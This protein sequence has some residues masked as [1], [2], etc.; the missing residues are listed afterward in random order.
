M[1]HQKLKEISQTAYKIL[2]FPES[3][4]VGPPGTHISYEKI[5]LIIV[6]KFFMLLNC[7]PVDGR[8]GRVP[9]SSAGLPSS[10]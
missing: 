10:T 5:G 6:Q 9:G 4:S 3:K 7:H 8:D 1:S 2:P